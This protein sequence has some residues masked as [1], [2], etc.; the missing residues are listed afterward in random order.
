[1]AVFPVVGYWDDNIDVTNEFLDPEN[2]CTA[3]CSL[4]NTIAG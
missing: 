1:M 3:Y 2:L 4:S